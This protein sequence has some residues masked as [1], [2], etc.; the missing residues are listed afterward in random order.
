M[1]L[2]I[3]GGIHGNEYEGVDASSRSSNGSRDA[4]RTDPEVDAIL[5]RGVLLFNSI[6]NPDG[7]I[8]SSRRTATGSTSTATS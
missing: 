1:P 2:F 3:Q 5:N 6:Q 4:V 8:T 7:R